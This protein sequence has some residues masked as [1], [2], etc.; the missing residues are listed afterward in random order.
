MKPPPDVEIIDLP[1]A[2]MWLDEKNG[3]V[4]AIS[5]KGPERTAEVIA[6]TL[7]EFRKIMG[8]DKIFLLLDVTHISE[9]T[10]EARDYVAAE[11][12]KYLKAMALI[13]NSV[14]GKTIANIFFTI[15]TQPYPTKMFN[16]EEQAKKWLKRYQ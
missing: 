9:M 3:I 12:P 1:T 16:D 10:R 7:E 15:K 2:T 5:K 11:F 8:H 14:F 13:S 6:G 4:C